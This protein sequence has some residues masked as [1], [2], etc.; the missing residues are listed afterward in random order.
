[1]LHEIGYWHLQSQ[2][3]EPLPPTLSK[4]KLAIIKNAFSLTI[5]HS[6]R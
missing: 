2:R 6:I 3:L 5:F 4:T 1:M